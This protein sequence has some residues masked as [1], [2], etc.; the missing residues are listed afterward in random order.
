MTSTGSSTRCAG[1]EGRERVL[2]HV[3]RAR[4][5]G[6]RPDGVRPPA[7]PP[8]TLETASVSPK[9]NGYPA[10]GCAPR[11]AAR[12]VCSAGASWSTDVL[13]E[14]PHSPG[15][16]TF[17][18][19]RPGWPT[20]VPGPRQAPPLRPCDRPGSKAGGALRVRAA[21]LREPHSG[22]AKYGRCMCRMQR[23]SRA[24]PQTA[25]SIRDADWRSSTRLSA[26]TQR[27]S[28]FVSASS[29]RSAI[30]R[31]CTHASRYT[32]SERSAS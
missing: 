14:R 9:E 17:P 5:V 30:A 6:T 4:R 7:S 31:S 12:V 27:V 13:W 2:G 3:L 23:K 19:G 29:R 1:S 32:W 11:P 24:R 28:N 25:S 22:A 20:R 15:A 10:P 18:Q 16:P 21:A 8:L 26:S